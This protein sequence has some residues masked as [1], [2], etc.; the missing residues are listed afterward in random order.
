MKN[1]VEPDDIGQ[2]EK[3]YSTSQYKYKCR[4]SAAIKGEDGHHQKKQDKEDQLEKGC[5]MKAFE[6]DMLYKLC[7]LYTSRCV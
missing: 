1:I 4:F 2:P 7:L 3:K 6:P 5:E